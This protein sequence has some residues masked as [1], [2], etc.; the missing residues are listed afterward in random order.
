MTQEFDQRVAGLTSSVRDEYEGVC[1][2]IDRI[3]RAERWLE[4]TELEQHLRGPD[5]VRLLAGVY[6]L[7][8]WLE[9]TR[10]DASDSEG[11]AVF[12][13]L[14]FVVR[15]RT[16]AGEVWAWVEELKLATVPRVFRDWMPT[17]LT[18]RLDV[19][20]RTF[21]VPKE[22]FEVLR[23]LT[24]RGMATVL[25]VRHVSL[26]QLQVLKALHSELMDNPNAVN[27]FRS[28]ARLLLQ[29]AGPGIVRVIDCA[30]SDGWPYFTMEYCPGGSLAERLVEGPMSQVQA[31]DL[32]AVIARSLDSVHRNH[33]LVHRDIKPANIFYLEGGE[34]AL[35]D[36]GLA[37]REETD[38]VYGSG[39]R[40]MPI[41]GTRGYIA[42][43]ILDQSLCVSGEDDLQV[44]KRAD[45][46]SLGV[47]LYQC[48]TGRLPYQTGEG[49]PEIDGVL[50]NPL[51]RSRDLTRVD[52]VLDAI[53]T[54]AIRKDPGS[55]FSS[56]LEL[57]AELEKWVVSNSREPVL[58]PPVSEPGRAQH[59]SPR[60]NWWASQ[61]SALVTTGVVAGV[62]MILSGILWATR[63]GTPAPTQTGTRLVQPP[64]SPSV[65][66]VRSEEERLR[67]A[68]WNTATAREL[69]EVAAPILRMIAGQNEKF[70]EN[71]WVRLESLQR[72]VPDVLIRN[73][74][75]VAAALIQPAF[76]LGQDRRL[77]MELLED[78]GDAELIDD[79][80]VRFA[81]PDLL[82]EL[83]HMLHQHRP[84]LRRL[85]E[86]DWIGAEQLLRDLPDNDAGR[87]YGEWLGQILRM[88]DSQQC[89]E[90]LAVAMLQGRSIILPL[91]E[92]DPEYRDE[93]LPRIWPT[94]RDLT[95]QQK[96]REKRFRFYAQPLCWRYLQLERSQRVLELWGPGICEV[97]VGP[98][99]L[100]QEAHPAAVD[101]LLDCR[102]PVM[103]CLTN[104][105]L[106]RNPDFSHLLS[107]KLNTDEFAA[108][109]ALLL[110]DS[111]DGFAVRT[112]SRLAALDDDLIRHELNAAPP[113]FLE[114]T[115]VV[116]L[117]MGWK[118]LSGDRVYP[119]EWAQVFIQGLKDAAM[120]ASS[121]ASTT[122]APMIEG[123]RTG[124]EFGSDV[125]IEARSALLE[126][127]RR[128]GNERV[129]REELNKAFPEPE[130]L[131]HSFMA[132]LGGLKKSIDSQRNQR[133]FDTRYVRQ[134]FRSAS[135]HPR[136]GNVVVRA[137]V[138]F[139][140]I[141]TNDRFVVCLPQFQGT[142]ASR[143]Y[144]E[145]IAERTRLLSEADVEPSVAERTLTV[146]QLVFAWL[147]LH[148]PDAAG[149]VGTS[150]S[151][152]SL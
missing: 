126:K 31:A 34:P 41:L 5:E 143:D 103:K 59:A 148:H 79:L 73:R 152:A 113:G 138:N 137:D 62:V 118:V 32:I 83:V 109:C 133:V 61:Q 54:R 85:R 27:Q 97:F 51:V 39:L 70:A 76:F 135:L 99:A 66:P 101:L 145:Y 117:K 75:H 106:R 110:F 147:L 98:D 19:R 119:D 90:M 58:P 151:G 100:R 111:S 3:F 20:G 93:F 14:G 139:L 123:F 104:E 40:R 13:N 102:Q 53:C 150:A 80:L 69:V 37:R 129:T 87:V 1:R 46:F 114:K 9:T 28:E 36:F 124:L 68:G 74:P 35:G 48:L 55:R 12:R 127:L 67:N 15:D 105:T 81:D 71:T 78:S 47:T 49:L 77:W 131:V 52:V 26:N 122:I 56:A 11:A 149:F 18:A 130:H 24:S 134:F 84:V 82:P 45:V 57:A 7:K 107:R 21:V 6:A 65:V 120:I 23:Q 142:I 8:L 25:L 125:V 43:E 132:I 64:V 89:L 141:R 2:A 116:Y 91:L 38:L 86:L 108:L 10:G 72:R 30:D 60:R 29:A 144:Q 146:R 128:T 115:P 44:W 121:G 94:F 140:R 63:G 88:S 136:Q 96:E 16:A 17:E 33:G 50:K 4:N 112:A 95:Y 22:R 92:A 42:P